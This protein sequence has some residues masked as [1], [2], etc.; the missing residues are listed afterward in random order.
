MTSVSPI[1]TKDYEIQRCI[2]YKPKSVASRDTSK[3]CKW[4]RK[5][6]QRPWVMLNIQNTFTKHIK[7][8][9]SHASK[10]INQT[11]ADSAEKAKQLIIYSKLP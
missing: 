8:W 1:T 6:F 11:L 2:W 3:G 5:F 4:F 10:L 9:E 7:F